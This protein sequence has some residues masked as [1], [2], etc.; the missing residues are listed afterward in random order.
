MKKK[1]NSNHGITLVA[2][3]IT[4]IIMTIIASITVYEGKEII[5]KSRMQTLETNMLTIQAKVKGYVEEID[6]KVWA[7]AEGTGENQK[8]GVRIAE[9][10]N[11]GLT[12]PVP[13]DGGS[14]I[15]TVTDT[16]LEKMG[17]AELT[18][19]YKVIFNNDY[20]TIDVRYEEGI[21]YKGTTIKL[22][23][24]LQNALNNDEE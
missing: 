3:V 21:K 24:E 16:G 5:V 6:S 17:L 14:V 10:N 11:R 22:L 8:D 2:L 12:N 7:L 9:F 19:E 1:L 18:G 4:I 13:G 15:Y 20:T 23:S